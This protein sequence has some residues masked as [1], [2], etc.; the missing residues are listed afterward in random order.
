MA[1]CSVPSIWYRLLTLGMHAT[2]LRAGLG[3]C[4][5]HQSSSILMAKPALT[6]RVVKISVS[7]MSGTKSVSFSVILLCSLPFGNSM[8]MSPF[9][10]ANIF[11]P[12]AILTGF[13]GIGVKVVNLLRSGQK[14]DD[15]PESTIAPHFLAGMAATVAESERVD[16]RNV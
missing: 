13:R 3:D 15:T 2:S 1:V 9:P 16:V 8:T 6:M 12:F 11:C 4:I 5:S 14:W 10:M 7:V